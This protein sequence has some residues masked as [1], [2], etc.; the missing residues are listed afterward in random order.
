MSANGNGGNGN[1]EIERLA[2][3]AKDTNI[4]DVISELQGE[5]I[6]FIDR[7]THA[8]REAAGDSASDEGLAEHIRARTA[9]M[10]RAWRADVAIVSGSK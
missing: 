10:Q 6:H 3:V 1:G 7:E 2:G 4:A 9:E 8:Y 5:F